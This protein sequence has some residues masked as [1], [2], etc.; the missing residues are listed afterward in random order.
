MSCAGE[1][2]L[3]VPEDLSVV[4]FDDIMV[5]SMPMVAL[6]TVAQPMAELAQ[7]GIDAAIGLIEDPLPTSAVAACG[8]AAGRPRNDRGP[9]PRTALVGLRFPAEHS[10]SARGAAGLDIKIKLDSLTSSD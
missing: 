2:G 9:C 6:T 1:L 8:A 3:R 7:R 10:G 4:G 5:A